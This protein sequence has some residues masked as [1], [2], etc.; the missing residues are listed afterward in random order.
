MCTFFI[1][2]FNFFPVGYRLVIIC[3]NEEEEKSHIISKLHTHRRPFAQICD[4]D[5]CQRYL[6]NH[7]TGKVESLSYSP[8]QMQ[9]VTA[10]DVDYE[11]YAVLIS[12]IFSIVT[13]I[14][15]NFYYSYCSSR[16]RLVTSLRSGMGKS[17][18]IQHMVEQL[19]A[20][21]RGI[22]SKAC[23]TVPLHGPQVSPDIVMDYLVKCM[24]ESACTR[25]IFH[26]DVAPSV[27]INE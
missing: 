12:I 11:K 8:S 25:S 27:S 19:Q 4:T 9:L 22:G 15:S 17:L 7:F 16:V 23:V 18:Y 20:K 6:K 14:I 21:I 1:F 26:L 13:N 10:P 5:Q 2:L 3:S 24:Q